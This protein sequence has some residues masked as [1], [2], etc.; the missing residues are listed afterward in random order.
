M[1]DRLTPAPDRFPDTPRLGIGMIGYALMG[2][3]HTNALIKISHMMY[4]AAAIPVL[5]SISGRTESAVAEAAA[6][7]GYRNYSTDWRDV[8]NDPAVQVLDNSEPN[9]VHVP[10]SLE[11]VGLGKHVICEKP[12]GMNAAESN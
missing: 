6:R 3:A 12:L 1:T 8:V 10:A 2:K 4:P 7:Y 9:S 5:E 11:A